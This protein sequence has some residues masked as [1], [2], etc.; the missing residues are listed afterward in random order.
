MEGAA[1]TMTTALISTFQRSRI[2]GLESAGSDWLLV[3]TVSRASLEKIQFLR[4]T[5][6]NSR[7]LISLSLS[8]SH[9]QGSSEL[10]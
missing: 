5:S 8:L 7:V 2:L 1:D 9:T 10:Q 4:G 6:L 3:P